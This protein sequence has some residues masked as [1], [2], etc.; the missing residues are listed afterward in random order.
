LSKVGYVTQ[1]L[2]LDIDGED[3]YTVTAAMVAG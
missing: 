3:L 2:S 1:T